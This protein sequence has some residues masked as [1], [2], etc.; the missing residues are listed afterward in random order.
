MKQLDENMLNAYVDGQLSDVERARV[1]SWLASHPEDR[2]T[3][4]AYRDQIE[5]LHQKYDPL[6]NHGKPSY[7]PAIEQKRPWIGNYWLATAAT[8][9]FFVT[10]V[11]TGLMV[12]SDPVRVDVATVAMGAHM[13]YASEVKHPVEVGADEQ[14]HLLSWLSLRLG[15]EVEAPRLD[16][17]GFQLL[18]GRLM[19]N[20]SR[21]AAQLM[22]ERFN[23]ERLTL[24]LTRGD[25]Q[26]PKQFRFGEHEG[27][28]AFFWEDETTSFV[29]VGAMDR[30]TLLQL[31]ESTYQQYKL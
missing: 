31:A 8:L 28:N 16:R 13:V 19:A 29:L 14:K 25:H 1:E 23:G 5:R 4:E 22:Y 30:R 11:A 15:R 9:I 7:R 6:L 12:K 18:G 27:V 3:V 24:Y 10:G 20:G 17:F 26:K 21:P 2:A